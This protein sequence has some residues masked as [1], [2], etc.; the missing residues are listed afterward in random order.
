VHAQHSPLVILC[1]GHHHAFE[2]GLGRGL[3]LTGIAVAM[4]GRQH[5]LGLVA[6]ALLLSTLSVGGLVVNDL[7]PKE[8]A[9]LLI[10]VVVVTVAIAPPLLDRLLAVKQPRQE[11]QS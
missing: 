11:Q 3:G 9:E 5:P 4:L 1:W 2:D 8:T 7:I 6:S 10:G